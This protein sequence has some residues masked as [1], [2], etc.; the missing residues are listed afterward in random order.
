MLLQT[1]RKVEA[2]T[3]SKAIVEAALKLSPKKR[4]TVASKILQS[5]ENSE[6]VLQAAK[7]ADE[8]WQAYLRGEIGSK[9]AEEVVARLLAKKTRKKAR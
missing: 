7:I 5:L 3:E 1:K 8:R 9:P 6:T 2:M 4:A